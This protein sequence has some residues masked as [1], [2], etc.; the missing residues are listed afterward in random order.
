MRFFFSRRVNLIAFMGEQHWDVSGDGTYGAIFTTILPI[1]NPR[2]R[3]EISSLEFLIDRNEDSP[4]R[5]ILGNQVGKL[6]TKYRS[7]E[8]YQYVDSIFDA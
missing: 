7:S 3:H 2:A 4:R 8:F 1:E 5:I 6:E